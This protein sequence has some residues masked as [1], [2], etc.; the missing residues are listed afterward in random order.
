MCFLLITTTSI[1]KWGWSSVFPMEKCSGR[2]AP[3]FFA[4][5]QLNVQSSRLQPDMKWMLA[6]I[7]LQR[8][9]PSPQEPKP[10]MAGPV[11]PN[12]PQICDVTK[13]WI[14]LVVVI[15]NV[16]DYFFWVRA[17]MAAPQIVSYSK[18]PFWKSIPVIATFARKL[19]HLVCLFV[20]P[21]SK[22]LFEHPTDP[23]DP[24]VQSFAEKTQLETT[25][26]GG[27]KKPVPAT[28]ASRPLANSEFNFLLRPSTS[29]MGPLALGT[30]RMPAFL[31]S[32][33]AKQKNDTAPK[34]IP[35]SFVGPK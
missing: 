13:F 21:N 4:S 19:H 26:I 7:C 25:A 30:P 23:T 24:T 33:G 14:R 8:Q 16:L 3:L 32:N 17:K 22:V 28:M 2:S 31:S 35:D 29:L 20:H 5:A 1:P 11:V 9:L 12:I 18:R 27:C 34:M 6:A 10:H 15:P